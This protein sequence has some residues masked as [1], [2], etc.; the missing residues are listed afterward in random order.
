MKNPKRIANKKNNKE[1]KVI[2]QV[3]AARKLSREEEIT[4]HT[5]PIKIHSIIKSKKIYSRNKIRKN[6]LTE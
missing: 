2:E 4:K 3:K 6:W 5:K 1:K